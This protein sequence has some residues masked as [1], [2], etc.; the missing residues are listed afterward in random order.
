[1]A[2]QKLKEIAGRINAKLNAFEADAAINKKTNGMSRFLRANA[3][4]SGRYVYVCYVSFHGHSALS[5]DAAVKYMNWL[6][7]GNAGTH[8]AMERQIELPKIEEKS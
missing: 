8:H 7:A 4:D 2:K 3:T 1:M 6:E 5:R